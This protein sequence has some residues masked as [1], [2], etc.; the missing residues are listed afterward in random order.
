[1]IFSIER[2]LFRNVHTTDTSTRYYND[3]IDRVT[4]TQRGERE[5]Q[6]QPTPTRTPRA[7]VRL[8][9]EHLSTFSEAYT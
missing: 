4:D 1:M 7:R 6:P 3:C 2:L 9:T 8:R 5:P